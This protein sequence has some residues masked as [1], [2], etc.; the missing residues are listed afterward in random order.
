MD[1]LTLPC[2]DCAATRV[3]LEDRGFHVHG[4]DA[5]PDR[6]GFCVIS[7]ELAAALAADAA[8]AASAASAASVPTRRGARGATAPAPAGAPAA[9]PPAGGVTATQARAAQAIVNVFETGAVLGLYGQ[10]TLIPGDTGHLTFGRSQTTLGS[11]NLHELVRRYC[12]NPGARFGTALQPWLPRLE[13]IDLTLDDDLVFGNLLRAS[14]DDRVMREVQDL[15]FDETY[16]RPA[17]RLAATAG[18]RT[19]LGVAVVY[20]SKVHGSWARIRDQVDRDFGT[21]AQRGEA[22]WI[23]AYVDAR[24]AW[25]AGGRADLRPTVYR[26]DAF[27]RLVDQNLWGLDLPLVVR[28]LEISATTLAAAPPGCYDGPAPGTR[29]LAVQEPLQRGLD[30]RLLQL[31][32]SRRGMD[33]RADGVYGQASFKSVRAFQIARGLPA[34]GVAEVALIAELV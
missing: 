28:G 25:L 27:R 3:R 2:A 14:A 6:P 5:A 29:S 26:M 16:W 32:L 10:V 13:S 20:D 8:P 15:F 30:V 11:G 12:A 1:Q 22:A 23:S 18:I 17:L 4:C 31:G 34:T 24:R 19:P 9:V 7:F 21:L 33:I